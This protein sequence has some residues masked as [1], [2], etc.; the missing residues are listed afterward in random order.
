MV[1]IAE[2]VST[3]GVDCKLAKSNWVSEV[4]IF[5]RGGKLVILNPVSTAA[6]VLSW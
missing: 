3:T 5:S 4:C 2:V 6:G 1:S